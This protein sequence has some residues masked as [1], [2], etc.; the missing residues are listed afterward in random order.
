MWWL[1]GSCLCNVCDAYIALMDVFTIVLSLQ[2]RTTIL[3]LLSR[4]QPTS[5]VC[6]CVRVCVGRGWK[7]GETKQNKTN[8]IF[9]SNSHRTT[10]SFTLSSLLDHSRSDNYNLIWDIMIFSSLHPKYLNILHFILV[11]LSGYEGFYF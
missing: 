4:W 6:V 1:E 11:T 2:V 3:L 8:P 10:L 7:W 5:L 9:L